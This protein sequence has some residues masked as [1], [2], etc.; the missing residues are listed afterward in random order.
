MRIKMTTQEKTAQKT[1]KYF[2]INN[3][4]INSNQKCP[5]SAQTGKG[6]A[7]VGKGLPRCQG[8]GELHWRL[9]SNLFPAQTGS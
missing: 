2:Y 8:V 7:S 6:N 3:M 9:A 1:G 4:Y 5:F